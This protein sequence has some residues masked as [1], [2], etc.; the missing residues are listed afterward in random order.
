TSP[1]ADGHHIITDIFFLCFS[2]I[3]LFRVVVVSPACGRDTNQ[4]KN[5]DSTDLTRIGLSRIFFD[6]IELMILGFDLFGFA[7]AGALPFLAVSLLLLSI[8]TTA[9]T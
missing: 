8:S 7:S 3:N 2:Q 1:K 6:I 9:P 5:T 4:K